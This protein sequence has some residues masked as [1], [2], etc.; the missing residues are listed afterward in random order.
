MC[1][2]FVMCSNCRF[3]RVE[4][5]GIWNEMRKGCVLINNWV[6]D[7]LWSLKEIE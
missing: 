5:V 3:K 6:F 7:N 2:L 4:S 1:L